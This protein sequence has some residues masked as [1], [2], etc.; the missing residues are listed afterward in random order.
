MVGLAVWLLFIWLTWSV[1]LACTEAADD[2]CYE[3]RQMNDT[4]AD[5][6]AAFEALSQ[7]VP[8][9]LNSTTSLDLRNSLDVIGTEIVLSGCLAVDQLCRLPAAVQSSSDPLVGDCGDQGVCDAAVL[10]DYATG[11]RGA[12]TVHDVRYSCLVGGVASTVDDIVACDTPSNYTVASDAQITLQSCVGACSNLLMRELAASVVLYHNSSAVFDAA[13]SADILPLVSCAFVKE[14]FDQGST[15]VCADFQ[16]GLTLVSAGCIILVFACLVRTRPSRVLRT[17]GAADWRH[18]QLDRLEVPHQA[19]RSLGSQVYHYCTK[20]VFCNNSVKIHLAVRK[21]NL[22]QSVTSA[23]LQVDDTRQL[24]NAIEQVI[25]LLD[26]GLVLRVL[27]VRTIGLNHAADLVDFAIQTTS[28]DEAGQF[29]AREVSI[30]SEGQCGDK[31]PLTYVSR[32]SAVTEK[33]LAIDER[34]TVLY[35][36]KN[37][38]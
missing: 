30:G 26:D 20:Y 2:V 23:Q 17:D 9:Q 34:L 3:A 14:T 28:S 27:S 8:C 13:V 24:L 18:R 37:C 6:L 1:H 38:A 16:Y 31:V 32:N 7:I 12:H 10:A 5:R 33:R 22:L 19:V 11:L 35:D 29:S 25:A 4:S 15:L 36:S 21:E